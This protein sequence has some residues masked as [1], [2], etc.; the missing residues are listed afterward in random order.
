M[1]WLSKICLMTIGLWLLNHGMAPAQSPP[2]VTVRFLSS[3]TGAGI[4]AARLSVYDL[5]NM[6]PLAELLSTEATEAG[7]VRLSPPPGEYLLRVQAEGFSPLTAPFTVE[8]E[9]SLSVDFF[10]DPVTLPSELE[11]EY[12]RSLLR[13]EA[14]LICGFIVDEQTRRPL[15][16]V[17]VT[18]PEAG[19]TTTSD[20]RGYF[21]LYLPADLPSATLQF[22]RSGYRTQIRQGV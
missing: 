16:G 9:H 5:R 10:L 21:R 13:P 6:P 15:S 2:E 18:S 7:W 14:M 1:R 11:P 19:V 3:A 8:A 4:P 22:A 20:A 12:I 17:Q